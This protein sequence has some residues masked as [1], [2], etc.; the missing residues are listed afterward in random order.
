MRFVLSIIFLSLC[1]LHYFSQRPLWLDENFILAN[2]QSKS[3]LELFGVLDNSQAFPRIHL[4]LIKCL[5]EIFDYHVLSLRFL[6]L[7]FMALSFF[8][9]KKLYERSFSNNALFILAI[10]SF[11]CSYRLTY[12]A[13]ELKPYAMDVLTVTLYCLFFNYQ[14]Q[15]ENRLPTR[16]LYLFSILLPFLIFFSYAGLF[17]FWMVA[18]NYLLMLKDNK[19][20]RRVLGLNSCL[21]VLCLGVLYYV[22][23]RYTMPVKALHDYWQGAFVSTASMP[24]FIDSWWEGTRKMATWWYGSS[25]FFMKASVIFIPFFL[26]SLFRYG[27]VSFK[28][29]GWKIFT[30]ETL[31]FVLYFELLFLSILRKYPFLGE[32]ITLF[33]APLV[34]T[35]LLKGFEATRKIKYIYYLFISYYTIYCLASLANTFYEHLLTFP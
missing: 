2:L 15:F 7:V 13:A 35:M 24:A 10:L 9:W 5:G 34:F 20:L 29:D 14:R 16:N 28:K 1:L 26:F 11:A 21:S 4:A 18:Y 19:K 3:F 30:I 27:L 23:L 25:R 32:R 31:C 8:L 33:M 17:V 22:D 6:S 12:Y